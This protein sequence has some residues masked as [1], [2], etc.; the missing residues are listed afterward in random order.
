MNQTPTHNYIIVTIDNENTITQISGAWDTT[1][2]SANASSEILEDSIIGANIIDY[3]RGSVT[4]MYYTTL[5]KFSRLSD[6]PL[7]KEYR[8]DSP[9]HQR[10]LSMTLKSKNDGSITMYH[11]LLKEIPFSNE[12][13]IE[14][15]LNVPDA[16]K[17]IQRCSIC[18]KLKY[19]DAEIWSAPEELSKLNSLDLKVFHT[20]CPACLKQI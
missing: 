18:N 16:Q 2:L 6:E 7:I 12:V 4:K 19:P 3:F 15:V 14:E 9:T 20:V 8:C 1:A 13:T 10:Y 17:Y 11:S 5:F